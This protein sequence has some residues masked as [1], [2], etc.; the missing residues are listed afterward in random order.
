MSYILL[1]KFQI[2]MLETSCS[3]EFVHAVIPFTDC[4]IKNYF[5]LVIA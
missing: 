3:T 1:M 5:D 2:Y 4:D